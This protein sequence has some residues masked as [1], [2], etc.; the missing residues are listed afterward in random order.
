MTMRSDS[1]WAT[2]WGFYSFFICFSL[3]PLS[4]PLFSKLLF[5]IYVA[6]MIYFFVSFRW[7]WRFYVT[8]QVVLVWSSLY[9]LWSAYSLVLSEAPYNFILQDSVGFLFYLAYFPLVA[10]MMASRISED[11]WEKFLISLGV[12]IS[13]FH[14][15]AFVAFYELNGELTEVTLTITNQFLAGIGTASKYAT[16]NGVLRV[17]SAM[18]TLLI[19]PT[20]L[21]F[22]KIVF[23]A[24]S[25]K[26]YAVMLI[27]I[28]GIFLEGHR[29]LL[30][31]VILGLFLYFLWMLVQAKDFWRL[32]F[33][34]FL[35]L[36]S[37]ASGVLITVTL[38]GSNLDMGMVLERFSQVTIGEGLDEDRKE[39][40]PALIEKISDSPIIGSGFGSHASLIRNVER[41][42]M[43]EIDFLAVVMKLGILGGAA[44][45][46]G[47]FYLL[48]LALK[49]INGERRGVIYFFAGFS[50]FL[51]SGTNGGF[52]MSVYSA[53]FHLFFMVSLSII[54]KNRHQEITCKTN[55]T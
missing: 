53:L 42:F 3:L 55:F 41:P 29:A 27:L 43:Y 4:F 37:V 38:L 39:Q 46:G 30:L 33:R 6:C 28:S 52:A 11:G 45:F 36:L 50:Y 25:I 51:Y 35:T 19:I 22:R 18:G 7:R 9:V 8:N 26:N 14:F 10:L 17:D 13:A 34:T 20:M 49:K 21:A 5:V 40:I 16:G 1:P 31:S 12:L 32:L 2:R 15:F 23:D 44:Y 48:Y 24:P 54:Y 47:Y